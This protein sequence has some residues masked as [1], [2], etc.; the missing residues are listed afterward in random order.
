MEA[1]ELID[2]LTDWR[3]EAKISLYQKHQDKTPQNS[4]SVGYDVGIVETCERL[5]DIFKDREI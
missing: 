1:D 4:Y 3:D 5:I 2:L